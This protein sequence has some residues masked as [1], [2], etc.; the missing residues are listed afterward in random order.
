MDPSYTP[1]LRHFSAAVCVSAI[2][3]FPP[4]MAWHAVFRLFDIIIVVGFHLCIAVGALCFAFS[5]VSY[6]VNLIIRNLKNLSFLNVS[7]E[8][9]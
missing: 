4:G 3:S 5:L 7:F 6:A 2:R 8:V 1:S 9:E